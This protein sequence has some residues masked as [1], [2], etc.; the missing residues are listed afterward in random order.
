[1]PQ[2]TSGW[3]F[4]KVH[5]IYHYIG[6][7][8]R[9]GA[10]SNYS[11]EMWEYLHKEVMKNAWKRSNKRDITK[12]VMKFN[13]RQDLFHV[14]KLDNPLEDNKKKRRTNWDEV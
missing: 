12:Q 14:L 11:A 2:Q 5:S 7:I 13:L 10:T 6:D 1:M 9:A 8:M 4:P 3:K